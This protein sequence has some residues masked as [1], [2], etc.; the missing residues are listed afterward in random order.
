M[1]DSLRSPMLGARCVG[2]RSESVMAC[3][4]PAFDAPYGRM[5]ANMDRSVHHAA[6]QR[7]LELGRGCDPAALPELSRL[8]ASPSNE[9][10]RLAVSAVGKLSGFGAEP[11]AAV[12]ALTPVALRDPHPQVQQ[13]ALKALKAYGAAAAGCL[14][15]L[16]DVAG[17]AK[18]KDYV[19]Q[20]AHSAAETIAGA[21]D[22]AAQGH[23]LRCMKCH[24]PVQPDE[25]DRSQKAFRRT[26][27][28]HCF[29][30]VYL[31]R[32][33]WETRVELNKTI[34]ARDGTL[35]QSDGERLIAEWLAA[36]RIPYRYDNR[37]R[38]IK[39]YAVRPDFY[40]PE[41][42]LYIEYWGMEDNLDYQIGM[43]EKKKLYQQAGKRLVS[44]YRREK[45]QLPHLLR[46]RLSRFMRIP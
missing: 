8:I 30:E 26:Y 17:N 14:D 11:E 12:R 18:Y 4:V 41:L 31:E 10:R 16:R 29:D 9:V 34:Q 15:D 36:H 38:I 6:M 21:V 37:F 46:E 19:R 45:S 23:V 24:R 43:L 42:D 13:Y 7:A 33:N 32:R 22:E 3:A 1:A 5:N 27:C 20:A 39:G 40:L 25:N 2:E 35:V 44:F 28:D